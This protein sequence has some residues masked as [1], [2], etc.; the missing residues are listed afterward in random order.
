MC[1]T[2]AVEAQQGHLDGFGRR[3]DFEHPSR[4]ANPTIEVAAFQV[5]CKSSLDDFKV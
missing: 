2:R 5:S 3:V 1:A 4:E